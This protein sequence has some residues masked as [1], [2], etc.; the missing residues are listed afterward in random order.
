[1]YK[2][3]FKDKP[4]YNQKEFPVSKEAL[5]RA[6]IKAIYPKSFIVEEEDVERG[7]I[8]AKR[9]FQRGKRT[10]VLALQ[11]RVVSEAE[12]KSTLYL[13]ALQTTE[14][15]YVADR[16]RFF[17]W[18]IPLPGGGGKEAIKVKEGERIIENKEFYQNFFKAVEKEIK[19]L[20]TIKVKQSE[21]LEVK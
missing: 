10:I 12:D 13:N 21:H 3:V 15:L 9:S 7:F 20:R 1:V 19:T 18:I 2:E 14:R 17:F 11:A 16:T 8:L 4:N 5:Y 6:V